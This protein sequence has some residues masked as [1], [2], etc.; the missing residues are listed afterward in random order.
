MDPPAE[1]Q[2]ALVKALNQTAEL[3]RN[4]KLLKKAFKE[5]REHRGNVETE[6]MLKIKQ[7]N[8]QAI[9]VEELKDRN[10]EL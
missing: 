1:Q 6:L 4:Y 7:V 3:K 9:M 5:E 10:L 8:D 2:A